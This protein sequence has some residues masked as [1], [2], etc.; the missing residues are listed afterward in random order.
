MQKAVESVDAVLLKK[1][2]DIVVARLGERDFG[3]EQLAREVG[4]SRRQLQRRV[5]ELTNETA[6]EFIRTMRLERAAQLIDQK[7]GN[8][9]EVAFM[10]GFRDPRHFS[11][12]FQK[13]YGTPPSRWA[14]DKENGNRD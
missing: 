4:L 13:Y 3:V 8:V 1:L 6:S 9:S 10:V 7:A 11:R 12:V 14:E 2:R 5:R